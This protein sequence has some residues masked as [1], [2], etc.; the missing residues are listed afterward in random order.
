MHAAVTAFAALSAILVGCVETTPLP[1]PVY[2]LDGIP[3]YGITQSLS[4]S[5]VRAAIAEERR[6]SSTPEKIY[7]IDIASSS[8]VHLYVTDRNNRLQEYHIVR[9]VRGMWKTQE[10]MISGSALLVPTD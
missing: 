5:D 2:V 10:R 7:S 6:V 8:E 1:P 9:R 4:K 3:V